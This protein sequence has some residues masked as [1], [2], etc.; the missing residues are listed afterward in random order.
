MPQVPEHDPEQ[1]QPELLTASQVAAKLGVRSEETISRWARQGKIASI[2]LPSGQ[3]RFR[4]E[5]VDAILAG[6]E[7]GAA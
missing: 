2:T 3:R 5:V 4:S 1:Q 7:A 6:T